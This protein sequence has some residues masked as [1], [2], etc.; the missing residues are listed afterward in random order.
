VAGI[1]TWVEAEAPEAER[2]ELNSL[3]PWITGSGHNV[4][5]TVCAMLLCQVV[6]K[7]FILEGA[8]IQR[9]N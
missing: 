3:T 8:S 9:K 2:G 6:L 1:G 7:N 5:G 4:V